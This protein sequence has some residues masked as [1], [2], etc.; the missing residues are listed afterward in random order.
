MG[1]KPTGL[2][3]IGHLCRDRYKEKVPRE[4]WQDGG[5]ALPWVVQN[6]GFPD[7][8]P[9]LGAGLEGEICLGSSAAAFL[10]KCSVLS[11]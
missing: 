3:C 9:T 2:W 8:S 7:T 1:L 10:R 5:R 11:L 6:P 4:C